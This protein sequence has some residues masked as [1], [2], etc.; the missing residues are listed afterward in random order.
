MNREG[1]LLYNVVL[2]Y[3]TFRSR[4]K[5]K[6]GSACRDA[7]QIGSETRYTALDCGLSG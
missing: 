1:L 6:P 3:T 2:S 5:R 7:L 4:S